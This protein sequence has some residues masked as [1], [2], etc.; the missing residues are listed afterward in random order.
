MGRCVCFRFA[1][2]R[3]RTK[4]L[5]IHRVLPRNVHAIF[6]TNAEFEQTESTQNKVMRKKNTD[7]SVRAN[8]TSSAENAPRDAVSR[9]VQTA[10]R[11]LFFA[12]VRFQVSHVFALDQRTRK[13]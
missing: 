11:T 7:S 2:K 13:H 3:D 6:F 10:E 5:A 4:L 12:A 1:Q 9:H 8:R